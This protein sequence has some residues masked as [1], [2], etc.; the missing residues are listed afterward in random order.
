M[1]SIIEAR[2]QKPF[3]SFADIK[4]RVSLL[5]DPEKAVVRRILLELEGNEKRYLF[6]KLF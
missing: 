6:V 3:E 4:I 5:P 1:I 2:E